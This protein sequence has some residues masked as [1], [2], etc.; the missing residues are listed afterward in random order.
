MK[1]N[2]GYEKINKDLLEALKEVKLFDAAKVGSL[3]FYLKFQCN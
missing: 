3:S 2:G 1:K